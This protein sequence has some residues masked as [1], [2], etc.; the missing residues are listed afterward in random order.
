V[1]CLA[2]EMSSKYA[3]NYTIPPE[4]PNILKNFTREVLR[5]QPTNIYE[6]GAIY[7]RQ[8]LQQQK[9]SENTENFSKLL[10]TLFSEADTDGSGFLDHKEFKSIL[11]RAQL[12]L[13]DQQIR[14][15]MTEAD[16]FPDGRI[17]YREFVPIASEVL[18]AA[19]QNAARNA[20]HQSTRHQ[21]H[22][23]YEQELT[24]ILA[25][26]FS[27]SD[28]DGSGKIPRHKLRALLEDGELGLTRHEIN[29]LIAT[30]DEDGD[31]YFSW[32]EFSRHTYDVL[33]NAYGSNELGLPRSPD[34]VQEI[35]FH[36]ARLKDPDQSGLLS[37]SDLPN[38]IGAADL[39][40][41]R[42]HIS[43]LMSA[44]PP[45]CDQAE[46]GPFFAR[47]A[48]TIFSIIQ[49]EDLR[50]PP[51]ASINGYDR[52]T[53]TEQLSQRIH[54]CEEKGP[55]T[56]EQLRTVLTDMEFTPPQIIA[57]ESLCA[58]MDPA[59]LVSSVVIHRAF[60]VLLQVKRLSLD[61]A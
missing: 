6:F 59:N 9:K 35:L 37:P 33:L 54:D 60:D 56:F 45:D 51:D 2:V 13:S 5:A 14:I 55:L 1:N 11:H 21:I 61:S 8:L 25:R 3:I 57:I 24:D 23:M 32:A 17:D 39:G 22:G 41:T 48:N 47:I 15:L 27:E 28:P 38:V 30:A 7:F 4:F 34:E 46:Y 12:G 20:L 42:L 19:M 36:A 58:G 31:G 29:L 26:K 52:S 40:L 53:M 10:A 50:N 44:I 43:A 16:E 18:K 49:G